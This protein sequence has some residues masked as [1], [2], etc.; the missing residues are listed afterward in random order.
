MPAILQKMCGSYVMKD[1]IFF[2][3]ISKETKR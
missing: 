3:P 1:F 2:V